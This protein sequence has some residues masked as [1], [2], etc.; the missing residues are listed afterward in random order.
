MLR[1]STDDEIE[2]AFASIAQLHVPAFIVAADPFLLTRRDKIVELAARHAVPGKY[3][4]RDYVLAGG[5]MSYGTDL[6]DVYQQ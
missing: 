2:L 4:F 3:F 5:L 6:A 1:V